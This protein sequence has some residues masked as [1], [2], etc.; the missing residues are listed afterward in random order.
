MTKI[1]DESV[2]NFR[3]NY[4]NDAEDL[5]KIIR[6]KN[7]IQKGLLKKL[8]EAFPCLILSIR[9]LGEFIPLEPDIFDIVII[10]EASQVS[11]AQAFPAILRGKKVVVLGDT[12]Q[13]SNVKSHNASIVANN[14]LLNR[15]SDIF[16]KSISTLSDNE[17][18]KVKDKVASFNIKNSILDFMRNI[19][20]YQC[21]LKKHF[22]GYIEIIGF[23]NETF[24]QNSLQIMKI[25]G[26][27]INDVIQFY[28][29]EA[30]IKQGKYKNTN[31]AEAEFILKELQ[32]LKDEGFKGTVG[33]ITPFT[34][35][36]KFISNLVYDSENWQFYQNEF[37]LKVMTFDSCQGDEKDIVYYSM[38]EKPNEDILKY[39]FPIKLTNLDDEDDGNRKA[40]RLNGFSRAKESVRFVMNKKP[41]DIRG[42]VGKALQWFKRNLEKP[43]ALEIFKNLDPKSPMEPVLFNLI[44]QTAFYIENREK[45]EIIPQFDKQAVI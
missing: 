9:E 43:D 26:K 6:A 5:R 16:R 4:K 37:K 11:I 27:S 7:Q 3:E 41:E 17:Q 19:A 18:E 15:V 42:E 13:Y 23:S 8:V 2:V 20:N 30:D 40:Q 25:R 10:D 45:I 31:Q 29:V 35:Q 38:V 21:S 28:Y 24:Y 12:K 1:L 22:R 36:Q 14:F 34:N 32:P 44:T 33:I 39:V